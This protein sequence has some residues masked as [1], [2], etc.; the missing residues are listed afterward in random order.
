MTAE[1][2]QQS[3]PEPSEDF[4]EE[5][6]DTVT[7]GAPVLGGPLAHPEAGGVKPNFF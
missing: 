2:S 4:P 7:G 6:L 3:A 5:L 1:Q